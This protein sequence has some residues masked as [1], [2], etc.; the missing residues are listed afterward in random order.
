MNAPI[1]RRQREELAAALHELSLRKH[2]KEHAAPGGLLK[3]IRY[4]WSVLEPNTPFVDGWCLHAICVH[5]E[6]VSDGRI[7]RLLINVPPGFAKPVHVD[8]LVLTD[9]GFV[10]LKQIEVG[11]RVLTHKGRFRRVLA[12]HEQ[13][14][15]PTVRVLSDSGRSARTAPDHP[16]LTTRGWI[17]AQDLTTDDY[18]GVPHVADYPE[19]GTMS[20][21]EARLLGYLVGDGCISQRS[22]G[23]VN[24]DEDILDD[25]EACAAACGFYALRV[26]QHPNKNVKATLIRLKSG[27]TR[28]RKGQEPP[29]L[30]WLKSHGLYLSNSYTK[31]IPDAVFASGPQALANFIGAYWSCDGTV[32]I[33][34]DGKKR[35]MVASCCTVSKRL[36][37]DIMRALMVLNIHG[38]LRS[39]EMKRES[40]KQAGGIYRSYAVQTCNRNE[41]AKLAELPGLCKRKKALAKQAFRDRFEQAIYEENVVS[42]LKDEPGECRCLTVEEDHSFTV[43]GLAVHNSLILNC[44]WPAWSWA[45]YGAHSRFVAFSYAAHLT[46]RDNERFRDLLISS[47][48]R[49]MYGDKFKVVKVGAEKV[50]SDKTGWKYASS[51][52]GVGTGERGNY[53]VLDD[54]HNVKEAESET[55][56]QETVRWFREAMQNRLNDLDRDAII[57]IMQR[58]HEADVSGCIIENY[59]DYVHLMIPMEYESGRHCAT[60][61]GWEDPREEDGELAWP[62]RYPQHV[63]APFQ[64][65]PYLWAGQYQQRPEPRGGGIIKREYWRIWDAEAM[66]R[67]DVRRGAYPPFEFILATFDGAY[68]EKTVNDPSAMTVWGVWLETNEDQRELQQI[69]SP[70][71]MLIDAWRKRLTLHGKAAVA[72][73]Y[74]E[75]K[76]EFEER[77]RE[78]WGIVEHLAATCRKHKIDKLLIEAKATGITV[79]QEMRRLYS[80]EGWTVQLVD[81]SRMGDKTARVYTVLHLF[82]DGVVWRPETDWAQMVEDECASFPRGTHDDLVDCVTMALTHLRQMRLAVRAQESH[83]AIMERLYPSKPQA[84][85]LYEA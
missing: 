23:F 63:L 20:P 32:A 13:G 14:V 15:L 70:K 19:R 12:V 84:K 58:V 28:P 52:G 54:P 33:R 68:T 72:P 81:P 22:L 53:V 61:I 24:M 56:R 30:T 71:L 41:V 66:R 40:L 16:F 21:E 50:S 26:A 45:V 11:D 18:L 10:P 82:A 9:K 8:E 60:E 44:F 83:D 1:S 74:G 3:F 64:S 55:V 85:R 78:G 29:V 62:E 80:N 51:V 65:L 37:E 79:A 6:A 76:E 7:N 69:G 38:D 46:T 17:A 31:F 36:A 39:R 67:N 48:Y 49:E 47:R 27:P 75:T 57:V 4:F 25:F 77:K 42:V 34:H 73:V 35:T 2:R 5:L 59:P 43:N